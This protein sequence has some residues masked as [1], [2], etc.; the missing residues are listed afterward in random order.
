MLE[1]EVAGVV[2]GVLLAE[3]GSAVVGKKNLSRESIPDVP[4]RFLKA[5][6]TGETH[7]VASRTAGIN[8]VSIGFDV[9]ATHRALEM[10]KASNIGPVVEFVE[11]AIVELTDHALEYDFVLLLVDE[12]ENLHDRVLLI[13]FADEGNSMV[14]G[15]VEV[16]SLQRKAPS[17]TA[18]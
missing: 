16:F 10:V 18:H 14:E 13:V 3:G 7:V 6:I 12:G 8:V 2:S 11:S 4:D 15:E 17:A 5:G 1:V 9:V